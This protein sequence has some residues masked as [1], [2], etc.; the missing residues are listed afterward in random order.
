MEYISL[1]SG[2][3]LQIS[4]FSEIVL[5]FVLKSFTCSDQFDIRLLLFYERAISP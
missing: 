4:W 5:L 3:N 2:F 1:I